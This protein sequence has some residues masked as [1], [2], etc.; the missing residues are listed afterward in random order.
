MRMNDFDGKEFLAAVRGRDYAHAG[1]EESINLV[2]ENIP[3]Q[4]SRRILDAGCG[5]GGTADYVQRQGWGQVVGIDIDAQSIKYAEEKYPAPE[6]HVCNVYDA[7]SMF[8]DSFQMIYLFNSFYAFQDKSAAMLSL[9]KAAKPGARLCLFDYLCYQP[10][11]L[12]PEVM[13]CQKPPTPEEYAALLQEAHWELSKTQNLDEKYLEWYRNFLSKF[14]VLAQK[15]IYPQEI[16]E[17]GRKKYSQLLFSLEQRIMG[18]I[19]IVAY[20]K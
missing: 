6:F 11:I 12:L 1:E 20:A 5:R 14:D 7:G 16:I 3:Q 4:S 8:P 15:N 2:F 18:G 19:L 13:L 17:E 9:R 10:K